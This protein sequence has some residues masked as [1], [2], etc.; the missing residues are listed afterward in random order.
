MIKSLFITGAS[1]FIGTRLLE[2][3]KEGPYSIRCLARNRE[4][5]ARFKEKGFEAVLG[6]ILDRESLGACME[7]IDAVVHLV[8]VI[9]ARGEFTFE[10]VH[11]TGTKNLVDAAIK[12][13]G[14]HFFYQSS[15]GASL[16]SSSRFLS[17]K[18]EAE[19]LV[20]GS[21]LTYTIFRPSLVV[22]EQDG[23]TDRLKTIIQMGPV[24]PVAGDGNAKFQPLD[25][26]DWVK[27]FTTV[28][29]SEDALGKT[30]E[31]GG[32]EHL[33]QNEIVSLMMETLGIKKTIVHLPVSF[34]RA[35]VPFLGLA[36]GLGR[37]IGRKIPAVTTEQLLLL[38]IDNICDVDSVRNLF[39]FD[40]ITLREALKKFITRG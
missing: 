30:Y 37:F 3:L 10:R 35:G 27:C 15:L 1:G 21:G 25:V 2:A 11:V 9:H 24:V 19:E 38:G 16:K 26:D 4:R 18:A 40:P 5:A 34:A 36:R 31:F 23:F 8:G 17:T 32:P 13:G 6:N 28:F 29:G 7:G 20:K 12:A 14:K 39:G 33:T 22:G